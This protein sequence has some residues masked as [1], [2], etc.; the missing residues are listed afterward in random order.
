MATNAIESGLLSLVLISLFYFLIP[1]YFQPSLSEMKMTISIG[2]SRWIED[3]NSP[4]T[5]HR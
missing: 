3:D 2:R 1:N 5:F 4:F